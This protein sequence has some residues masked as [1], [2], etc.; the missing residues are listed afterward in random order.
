VIDFFIWEHR[1]SLDIEAALAN[2]SR[3]PIHIPGAI[4]PF[5][6]LIALDRPEGRVEYC[7]GNVARAFGIDAQRVLGRKPAELLGTDVLRDAPSGDFEAHEPTRIVVSDGERERAWDVFVHRHLG[8]SIIELEATDTADP[9]AGRVLRSNLRRA[10]SSLDTSRSVR[11]LSDRTCEAVRTL[12]GFDGVM[13]Y[14]FHAD[15]HGEVIAES[16]AD[17]FAQYLGLHY[18]ASD[19]PLQARAMFLSNWVRMIPDRDYE[20]VPLLAASAVDEPLDLSRSLLRSVSPIHIQ[21]LRNMGV[22]ASLTLSLIHN[23]ELWGLVACHHYRDPRHISFETR[24]ACETIARLASSQLG[25]MS[26]LETRASRERATQIQCELEAS[27]KAQADLPDGLTMG[28]RTALDLFGCHG[29]AVPGHDGAW[30]RLGAVP[31]DEELTSLARWLTEQAKPDVFQTS[32][33]TAEYPAAESFKDCGS[34]LLAIRIPKGD[35]HYLMWFRPEVLQTVT[36]AGNPDKPVKHESGSVRLAPRASFDAWK[37]V[38]RLT[39]LPW[40]TWEVEAASALRGAILAI[41]LQ[42]Q[43]DREVQARASAELA[44]EQ[45]E[46]LLA[47]VSHDLKNPVHSLMVGLTLVQKTL[48]ADALSKASNII[49]GMHRSLKGMNHLIDDLLSVSKLESGTINLE[50]REHSVGELLQ[51]VLQLLQPIAIER[52]IN[53]ET[54]LDSPSDIVL[55][56]D[57]DRLLQVFSNL[58]GNALKFTPAR[59]HVRV[60]VQPGNRETQFVV[61]DTG[62]GITKENLPFVFDR[63][64]QAR[65]TQR[66]GTGLGLSI[67][68]GIVEAHGGRIWVESEAGRGSIFRFTIPHRIAGA[69]GNA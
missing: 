49:D 43:Y 52:G 20:P 3:E 67:A 69:S 45:K 10:I 25:R 13:V 32:T 53:L 39:S 12:T 21:Y 40:E 5:G 36:W 24:A 60:R 55:R 26:E 37:Q 27:M 2:C 34:G 4:Q 48:S 46:Q 57:R 22:A 42:R 16:K 14:K 23:G 51:D 19:I 35:R 47:M 8:R 18:P 7:S 44:N 59:G 6:V 65:Q 11:E 62:A 28:P 56:V 17:E 38:V 58:V 50:V 54:A 31:S 30:L 29:A 33:L 15:G 61:S 41:D 64:W 9:E 1:L 66:L 63:F 68:K